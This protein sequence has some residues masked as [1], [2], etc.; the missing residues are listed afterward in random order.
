M[1]LEQWLG[2]T[3]GEHF[4]V[5]GS[6]KPLFSIEVD[7]Q[8]VEGEKNGERPEE[9]QV[10]VGESGANSPGDKGGLCGASAFDS[11]DDACYCSQ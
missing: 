8:N 6:K 2:L 5:S 4:F 7:R 11:G 3:K 9:N 1:N 10:E